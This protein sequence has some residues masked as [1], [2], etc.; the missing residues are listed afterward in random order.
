MRQFAR[1]LRRIDVV[2]NPVA[3]NQVDLFPPRIVCI[4]EKTA[5]RR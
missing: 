4:Q 3:I 5:I 2:K 1:A